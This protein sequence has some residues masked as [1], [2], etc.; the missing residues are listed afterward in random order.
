MF[1]L[2]VGGIDLSVPWT[3]TMAAIV[4]NSWAPSIGL[5]GAILAS[6]G[7]LRGGRF[8]QRRRA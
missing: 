2:L 6:L 7:R 5:V 3:M 8:D 4:T 1:V